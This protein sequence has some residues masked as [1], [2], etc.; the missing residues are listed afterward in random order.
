MST[1][2]HIEYYLG[3][4]KDLP[5]SYRQA[6]VDLVVDRYR[7]I[8]RHPAFV[9]EHVGLPAGSAAHGREVARLERQWRDAVESHFSTNV[10]LSALFL[11]QA[12]DK[13][14]LAA[15][16]IRICFGS[17]DL[18]LKTI[19]SADS[20]TVP[21][22]QAF[23]GI[24]YLDGTDFRA[25]GLTES[26]CFEGGRVAVIRPEYLHA[27][28][29]PQAEMITNFVNL[30]GLD[31][32]SGSGYRYGY[33]RRGI[34]VMAMSASP[35]HAWHFSHR[36]SLDLRPLFLAGVAP[37]RELQNPIDPLHPVCHSFLTQLAT[38]HP[39]DLCD[40]GVRGTI[41]ALATRK[42]HT[43][44]KLRL[45][46]PYFAPNSVHNRHVMEALV[47]RSIARASTLGLR[48]NDMG[49]PNGVTADF[50]QF[51]RSSA[52]DR[53]EPPLLMSPQVQR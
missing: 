3:E 20:R 7:D 5:A 53:Q 47:S 51:T 11:H 29:G 41:R 25:D 39:A 27:L 26:N 4:A 9:S 37:S 28:D 31:L 48:I 38:H 22:H 10:L 32:V 6:A 40:L 13:V 18:P 14:P 15:A 16:V 42:D 43:L 12:A 21:T 33:K 23:D 44:R 1:D 52:T 8:L 17:G 46:L 35:V 30:A 2:T 50:E 19:G 45:W 49:D 36:E 24:R 34:V